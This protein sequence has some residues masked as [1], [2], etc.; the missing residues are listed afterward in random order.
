MWNC[1]LFRGNKTGAI[2]GEGTAHYSEVT[3]RLLLVEEELPT[4]Q[5]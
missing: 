5:K 1:P 4:R 3:P 2:S